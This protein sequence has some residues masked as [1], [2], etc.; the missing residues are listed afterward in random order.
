MEEP[1]ASLVRVDRKPSRATLRSFSFALGLACAG[2]GV[3]GLIQSDWQ[4]PPSVDTIAAGIG[5]VAIATLGVVCPN[6]Y[7][8]PYVLLGALTYPLRWLAAMLVLSVL[9]FGVLTP[10]AFAVRL[11]RALASS[12]KERRGNG[13]GNGSAWLKPDAR[14]AKTD[15][16]RQF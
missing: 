8:R 1:T 5:S 15:Y 13:N 14:A 4:L 10:I 2:R 12:S 9:Y 3:W 6:V 11:A 7:R 16:F